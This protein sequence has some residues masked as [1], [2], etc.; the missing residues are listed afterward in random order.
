MQTPI[1]SFIVRYPIMR[2]YYRDKSCVSNKRWVHVTNDV[3]FLFGDIPVFVG[4][5]WR[6]EEW[7]LNET[8]VW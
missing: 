4:P 1:S 6:N 5:T 7:G 8:N 2:I 3:Q